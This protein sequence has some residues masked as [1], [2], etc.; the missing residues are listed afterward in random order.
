MKLSRFSEKINHM[1]IL[2]T[3]IC[4]QIGQSRRNRQISRNMQ[5]L[6]PESGRNRQSEHTNH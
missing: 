2:Q 6:K 1:K 4:Q 5:P 3:G